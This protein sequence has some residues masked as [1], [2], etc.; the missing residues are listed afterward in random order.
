MRRLRGRAHP[1]EREIHS[2]LGTFRKANTKLEHADHLAAKY[3]EPVY[4]RE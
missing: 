2:L 1:T 4:P 3:D